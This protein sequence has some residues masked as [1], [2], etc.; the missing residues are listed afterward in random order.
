MKLAA[1]T[2]LGCLVAAPLAAQQPAALPA[3][4]A[5]PTAAPAAQLRGGPRLQQ[6]FPTYQPPMA[7][8]EAA[9]AADKTTIT[10]STL[11]LVLIAVLLILLLT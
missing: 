9:V 2:L 5:S 8:H 4:A 7:R 11:G 3:P 10:I 1:L 6:D